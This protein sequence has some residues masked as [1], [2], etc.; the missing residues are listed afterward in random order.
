MRV[1]T[2]AFLGLAID[3]KLTYE[4]A[5]RSLPFVVLSRGATW[6]DGGVFAASLIL[7]M[8]K[9]WEVIKCFTLQSRFDNQSLS[10][11]VMC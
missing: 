5:N 7:A 10:V 11:G 4:P 8:K 1:S 9:G 2:G 6:T 3:S